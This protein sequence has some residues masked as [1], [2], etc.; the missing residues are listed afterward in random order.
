M[1]DVGRG[2]AVLTLAACRSA[3]KARPT[4]AKPEDTS[5]LIALELLL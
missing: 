2:S 1:G 3:G 5:V 4:R